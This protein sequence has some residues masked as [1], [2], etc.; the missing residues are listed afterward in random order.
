[1]NANL[2]RRGGNVFFAKLVKLFVILVVVH[3]SA[4]VTTSGVDA[5]TQRPIEVEDRAVVDGQA[6]P[7]PDEAEIQTQTLGG[8]NSMS[9]VARRLL[10][11]AISNKAAGDYESAVG[12]LERALRIEPRNSLLWTQLAEVRFTQKK[13][14]QAVQLAAK[15]NTLVGSDRNLRRRNWVLMANAHAANGNEA[16]AQS[17]RD[18]LAE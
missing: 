9:V 7:L 8:A 6:L 2:K 17:F 15:S 10:S 11:S 13:F 4:C 5:P 12:E 3:L 14:N 16:A 18:K 1:M